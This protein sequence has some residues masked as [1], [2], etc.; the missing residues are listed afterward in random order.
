MLL[1]S[2]KKVIFDNSNL[3]AEIAR[4]G[5]LKKDIAL[6]CGISLT[7]FYE[8]LNGRREW[9]YPEVIAIW[10]NFFP[11]KKVAYLFTYKDAKNISAKH[12]EN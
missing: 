3:N 10:R 2:K 5:L 12:Y 6:K 7:S 9:T 8:K 11:D 1:I 4:K